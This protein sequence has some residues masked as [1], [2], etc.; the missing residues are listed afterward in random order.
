[1]WCQ[2]DQRK[3]VPIHRA[4]ETYVALHFVCV[5]V[6]SNE[7]ALWPCLL[8]LF[9]LWTGRCLAH[10]TVSSMIQIVNFYCENVLLLLA[11]WS[12][13]SLISWH[14][15]LNSNFLNC[16]QSQSLQSWTLLRNYCF[17]FAQFFVFTWRHHFPKLQIS[18]PTE[19]LV[20][21]D[22]RP[23]KNLTFYDV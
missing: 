13:I 8:R 1:M 6:S 19:V 12:L 20:T 4:G 10:Q 22:I 16:T 17:Y 23:Y 2:N 9:Y 21:S 14:P 5:V 18:N 11:L 3:D 15:E 7:I